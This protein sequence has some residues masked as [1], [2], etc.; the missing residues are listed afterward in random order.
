MIGLSWGAATD[1]GRVRQHN[2]D[3]LLA[4][5]PVFVIADGMGGHQAGEVASSIVVD[6]FR[7]LVGRSGLDVADIAEVLGRANAAIIDASD[8]A[9]A[10]GGM[11]TTVVGLVAIEQ[12]GVPYWAAF[13]VGDSRIY[14]FWQDELTQ[15]T[16]DHSYVQEL[17]DSGRLTPD[18]ARSHPDRNVV[19]RA[20]GQ[21]LLHEADFWVLPPEPG[22][23]FLLCS[24]GLPGDLATNEILGVLREL[25]D[26][27]SAADALVTAAV[28]AGGRD[29]VTV[30]VIDVVRVDVAAKQETTTPRS[31]A[32]EI[33][34]TRDVST[35]IDGDG[36]RDE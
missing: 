29:N 15:I 20:L 7:E 5:A 36:L 27:V 24:D 35:A 18:D 23:R 19:T 28:H 12:L 10:R 4:D 26:P 34:A 25:M 30:V 14:R 32:M 21:A 11:G 13:N 3:A 22:E 16:I 8:V 9:A 31:V 1:N 2:E 33:A 17:I 6:H